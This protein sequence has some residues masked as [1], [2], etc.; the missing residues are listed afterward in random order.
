MA[1]C[2]NMELTEKEVN[3]VIGSL[4]ALAGMQIA[5]GRVEYKNA[6]TYRELANLAEKIEKHKH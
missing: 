6:E 2:K 1:I 3:L 4:R 5:F